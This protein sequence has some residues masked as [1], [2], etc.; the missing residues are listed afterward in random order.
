MEAVAP[1]QTRMSL[2]R[3][4]GPPVVVIAD[5]DAELREVV[6]HFLS[7]RGYRVEL[8]AD[9]DAA[10]GLL[11][12]RKVEVLV[13]ELALCAPDRT[14]LLALARAQATRSIAIAAEATL[15]DREW[16]LREGAMR[17][18]AKPL[19]L[20]ELADAVGLASDCGDG[21]HGW[22]HRMSL[23]DVL[24]MYHHAGQSLVLHVRGRVEGE[25]ALRHG[26]LVH[27]ECRGQV[28][29]P[30]LIEL[31]TAE[32][33]QLE[34]A[35]LAHTT[36]TL[37]GP[38]DHVLLDGLRSLDEVRGPS[39]TAELDSLDGWLE[40][41]SG[42]SALDLGALR[43]WLAEHAPGAGAWRVDPGSGSIERI[44][45]LGADPASELASPP[46]ALG[47][48]VEL[49][50]L[51]DPSWS[52]VELTSGGTASA[53]IRVAGV[54]VAFA[55]LVSGEAMQRRFRVESARL[56]RWLA[57]HLRAAP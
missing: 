23:I 21:F 24:Q 47:W 32:R 15:H 16:A 52:H 11:R 41:P 17:V 50:E 30:A 40:E 39:A 13:S 36:R 48:A 55:R 6:R 49:A 20:L 9:G 29:M 10:A 31:L 44:D 34:T 28:G 57:E 43:G 7:A 2:A 5:R 53:I 45:D 4:S 51:A 27:A 14:A 8:A 42:G 18:L 46:G 54:V 56:A 22:M 25:I 38:F 26:E 12:D 35:A 3:A 37:S 33:G 19:S 1:L